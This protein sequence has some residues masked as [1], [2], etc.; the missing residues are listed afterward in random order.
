MTTMRAHAAEAGILSEYC[1]KLQAFYRLQV[2]D[3]IYLPVASI[4]GD[5]VRLGPCSCH[6]QSTERYILMRCF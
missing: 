6:W 2:W 3:S 5:R 4:E 1:D